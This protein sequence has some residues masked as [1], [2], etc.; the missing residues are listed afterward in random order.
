MASPRCVGVWDTVG[1]VYNTINAL[2]IQDTSLPATID[3][4]LHAVSLQENRGK[5]LPTLW[6]I[7]ANGLRAGQVFKQVNALII[8]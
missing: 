3:T 5:F 4:A 6:T 8:Y 2:S 7:P 1:S